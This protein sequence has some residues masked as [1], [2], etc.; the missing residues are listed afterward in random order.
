MREEGETIYETPRKVGETEKAVDS[1]A[2]R[3]KA[4]K[5][6]RKVAV[7]VDMLSIRR[8]LDFSEMVETPCKK[9]NAGALKRLR[10]KACT[11]SSG[12]V[13]KLR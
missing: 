3:L 7:C 2:S 9:K 1:S 8:A 11:S 13:L 10:D 6:K 5:A 4:R 12:P